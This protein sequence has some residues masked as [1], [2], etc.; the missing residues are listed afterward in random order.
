MTGPIAAPAGLRPLARRSAGLVGLPPK[1]A[2]FQVRA[3]LLAT[4]LGDDFA[5]SAATRPGDLR[6]LLALVRGR[7]L[8][9]ELGTATAWTTAGLALA[10]RLRRVVSFDPV[11][12]PHRDRY[13]ALLPPDVRARME[14]VAV[15]GVDGPDRIADPV[16]VLFIDSTHERDATLAEFAAWAPR[17]ARGA[18]VLF[19]DYGN[20]AFPGVEQAVAQLGLD[21]E[22]HAGMYLWHA[23][24]ALR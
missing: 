23:P 12:Q 16:E 1:V 15:P 11:V 24:L 14:L 22:E 7:R 4:R 17:L 8:V 19:H 10:D 21:G 9:V 20:P 13:L 2:A 5:L 18:L 6:E 3:M